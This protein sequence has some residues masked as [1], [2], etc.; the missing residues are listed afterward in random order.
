MELPTIWSQIISSSLYRY[1][2]YFIFMPFLFSWKVSLSM[3]LD[4]SGDWN[5]TP[6]H[7]DSDISAVQGLW[8]RGLVT[9]AYLACSFQCATST[10][11]LYK[12]WTPGLSFFP[13][14]R[15]SVVK[16]NIRPLDYAYLKQNYWKIRL[17]RMKILVTFPCKGEILTLISQPGKVRTFTIL[18]KPTQHRFP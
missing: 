17:R 5:S 2:E 7:S 9:L 11:Q 8:R 6:L 14:R 13:M 16:G 18:V 3:P 4:S 10:V 1:E 12:V 15:A